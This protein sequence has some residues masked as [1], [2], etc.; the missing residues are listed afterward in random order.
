M[1]IS[2]ECNK[3]TKIYDILMPEEMICTILEFIFMN[4][5]LHL[6]ITKPNNLINYIKSEL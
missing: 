2:N 6:L 5:L 3:F 4:Y 1:R